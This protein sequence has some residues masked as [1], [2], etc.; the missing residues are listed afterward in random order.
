MTGSSTKLHIALAYCNHALDHF[1]DGTPQ[2]R[3]QYQFGIAWHA[4][5]AS[6]KE[7]GIKEG[8]TLTEDEIELVADVTADRLVGEPHKY[9]GREEPP[10]PAEGVYRARDFAL[11]RYRYLPPPTSGQVEIGLAIDKDGYSVPFGSDE[12]YFDGVLDYRDFEPPHRDDD[13]VF[14]YGRRIIE[15]DKSS[16]HDRGNW[17]QS[18]QA[19]G[20][21]LLAHADDLK[22]NRDVGIIERRVYNGRTETTYS[23]I[24]NVMTEEGIALLDK[25]QRDIFALV[26]MVNRPGPR[27]A[28]PGPR[29][30]GCPFVRHCEPAKQ[31]IGIQWQ[32][33]DPD[34]ALASQYA[35]AVSLVDSLKPFVREA[36]KERPVTVPGGEVGYAP[37]EKRKAREGA[38]RDV[39]RALPE[40]ISTSDVLAMMKP[41]AAQYENVAKRLYPGQGPNKDPDWSEH[42]EAFLDTVLEIEITPKFGVRKDEGDEDEV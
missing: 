35:A 42:R 8:R 15:D 31:L 7:L 30:M 13:G 34:T 26:E 6:I 33:G 11:K 23:D 39:L 4:I 28:N 32:E 3:D 40:F 1:E 24:V 19:K 36:S 14:Q 10:P 5:C 27:M 21:T 12:A 37:Q 18:I 38:H 29:C 25:W 22:F 9:R 2:V 41:G 20:Y 16:W 17:L